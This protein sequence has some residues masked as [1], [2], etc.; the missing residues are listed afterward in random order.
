MIRRDH[1]KR[2]ADGIP[3]AKLVLIPGDHFVAARQPEAFNR[4]VLEFLRD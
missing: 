1:T 4:A 2:I 3:G